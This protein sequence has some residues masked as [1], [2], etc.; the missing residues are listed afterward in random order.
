LVEGGS[1]RLEDAV[2]QHVLDVLNRTRGNRAEAATL[3]GIDRKTLRR[4]LRQYTVRD[5]KARGNGTWR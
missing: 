5:D 1:L 3:L 4:K 2:R